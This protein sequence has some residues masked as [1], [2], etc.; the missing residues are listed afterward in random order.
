M[1]SLAKRS[2]RVVVRVCVDGASTLARNS[3]NW[4]VTNCYLVSSRS[5]SSICLHKEAQSLVLS[6]PVWLPLMLP[7]LQ[8]TCALQDPVIILSLSSRRPAKGGKD[9]FSKLQ[10][11]VSAWLRLVPGRI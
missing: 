8:F 9:T 11:R 2:V 3:T 4:E 5:R 7:C 10:V 1:F 6:L